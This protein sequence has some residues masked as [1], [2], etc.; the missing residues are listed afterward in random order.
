MDNIALPD[1]SVLFIALLG[2]I[3]PAIFWLWFWLKED[4]VRPEPRGLLFLLF[5]AGMLSVVFVIPVEKFLH[6]TI[7]NQTYLLAGWAAVEEIMKFL[8][9]FLLASRSRFLDEP[10]DYAIMMLTVALGFAALENTLF[11]INPL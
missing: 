8:A 4:S 10:I 2:G 6:E 1:G 3:L 7:T 9:F 5:I 11:I